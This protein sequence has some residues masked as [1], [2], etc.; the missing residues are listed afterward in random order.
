MFYFP[1]I[2]ELK[3]ELLTGSIMIM[4]RL[5]GQILFCLQ[6]G[7]VLFSWQQAGFVIETNLY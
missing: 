2:M 7:M 6:E 4:K 1:E 5:T 3:Q